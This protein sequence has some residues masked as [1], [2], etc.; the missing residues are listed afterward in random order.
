N[1][2]THHG[3]PRPLR[4][5]RR[6]RCRSRLQAR[7][8]Q[9]VPSSSSPRRAGRGRS[10]DRQD[11]AQRH[12]QGPVTT[13]SRRPSALLL[14]S[15]LTRRSPIHSIPTVSTRCT[16]PYRMLSPRNNEQGPQ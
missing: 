6:R 2:S 9:P 13:A 12:G 11:S 8:A 14:R 16:R 4:A 3:I 7:H 1:H 10:Q 5:L 15:L